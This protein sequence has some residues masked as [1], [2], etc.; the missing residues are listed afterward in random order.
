MIAFIQSRPDSII[1]NIYA[2]HAKTPPFPIVADPDMKI[3][4]K[5]DVMPSKKA[6]ARSIKDIPHW[7]R[8]VSRHGYKQRNIDGSLFMAPALF[9]VDASNQTILDAQ[10]G[11]SFYDHSTFTKVYESLIFT[12]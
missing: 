8:S 10:Y 5:Y 9:V 12:K 7:V 6:L 1:D 2:K 3:F 11:K 4:R